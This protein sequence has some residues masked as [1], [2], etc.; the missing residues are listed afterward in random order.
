M[1]NWLADLAA[2]VSLRLNLRS[3]KQVAGVVGDR[4]GL[5]GRGILR[6]CMRL[7]ELKKWL[8]MEDREDEG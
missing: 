5:G 3:W 7:C 4:A 6:M 8:G 2:D 1:L